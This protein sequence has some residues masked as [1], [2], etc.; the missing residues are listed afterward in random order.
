MLFR[1]IVNGEIFVNFASLH[2]E[3]GSLLISCEDGEK[4]IGKNAL[5]S[6]FDSNRK[7]QIK[8][9]VDKN[10]RFLKE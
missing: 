8:G 3:D 2:V 7:Y 4:L 10:M 6:V 9:R 5:L 1:S